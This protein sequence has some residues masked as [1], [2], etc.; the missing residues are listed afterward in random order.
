MLPLPQ[1]LWRVKIDNTVLFERNKKEAWYQQGR[2]KPADAKDTSW[3][4]YGDPNFREWGE[5]IVKAYKVALDNLTS[6]SDNE[7]MPYVLSEW[8]ELGAEMVRERQRQAF[9]ARRQEAEANGAAPATPVFEGNAENVVREY[10]G[11][12]TLRARAFNCAILLALRVVKAVL[13][14]NQ[15]CGVMCDGSAFQVYGILKPSLRTKNQRDYGAWLK[16]MYAEAD[17]HKRMA[18]LTD[19]DADEDED[20]WRSWISEA[21]LRTLLRRFGVQ[22]DAPREHPLLEMERILAHVSKRRVLAQNRELRGVVTAEDFVAAGFDVDYGGVVTLD[23]GQNKKV[24]GGHVER[25]GDSTLVLHPMRLTQHHF[26][27]INGSN[28]RQRAGVRATIV[29]P[30]R[31]AGKQEMRRVEAEE[32]QPWPG[33]HPPT[34]QLTRSAPRSMKELRDETR[35]RLEHDEWSLSA[36]LKVVEMIRGVVESTNPGRS[37]TVLW[38]DDCNKYSKGRASKG[39]RAT[40]SNLLL[41]VL[42][43]HFLVVRVPEEYT[44]QLCPKCFGQLHY[45]SK[46]SYRRKEC[47]NPEC[48]VTNKDGEC[49]NFRCDRDTAAAVNFVHILRYM[50][51]HKGKRPHVFT[52]E[53]QRNNP[54][55]TRR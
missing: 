17:E 22:V 44:S 13:R 37:V 12:G 15:V 33:G 23:V 55:R 50:I 41:R 31:N 42:S 7:L 35:L 28:H 49:V 19:Y 53:W 47:R 38:G 5:E 2:N 10:E 34:G 21:D 46:R 4:R 39:A 8:P 30:E 26:A 1:K 6:M 3:L 20:P 40:A 54:A 14:L 52:H 24:A 27:Q 25:A 32:R 9:D 36:C 51:A 45:A 11:N 43:E 18:A 16:S 29:D 48:R